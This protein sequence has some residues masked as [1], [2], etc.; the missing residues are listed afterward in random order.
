MDSDNSNKASSSKFFLGWSLFGS[1]FVILTKVS[2]FDAPGDY[3]FKVTGD[4]E[5]YTGTDPVS[6]NY[7]RT[8]AT[9]NGETLITDGTVEDETLSIDYA[10]VDDEVLF[11][12]L[13]PANVEDETL[14]A[15]VTASEETAT[16]KNVTVNDETI[17]YSA[18]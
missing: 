1:T 15:K 10:A 3:I 7:S 4:A 18:Q 8:V 5:G 9:V 6:L 11:C 14:S 13:A 12:G 2:A 16:L 17:I